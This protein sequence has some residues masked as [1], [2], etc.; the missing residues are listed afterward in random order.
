MQLKAFL[1]PASIAALM[2][3]APSPA[4]ADGEGSFHAPSDSGPSTSS[5]AVYR[6]NGAAVSSL[7]QDQRRLSVQGRLSGDAMA[8][9]RLSFTHHSSLGLSH[10]TA[11]VT[12]LE[13]VDGRAEVSGT[14]T[15]GKT[16]AG[17]VL[18]GKMVAFTLNMGGEQTFT[19]PQIGPG[20]ANC[21]GGR[22]ETVPVTQAGFRIR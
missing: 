18:D 11:R 16:A 7:P 17:V 10:F 21:G 19:L 6:I 5:Q 15:K 4:F 2:F 22:A 14:I 13:F 3:F 9:G 8:D 1:A 12:C 20:A